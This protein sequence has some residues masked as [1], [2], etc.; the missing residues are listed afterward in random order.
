MTTIDWARLARALEA[1]EPLAR[2]IDVPWWVTADIMAVTAPPEA[3]SYLLDRN[4]KNLVASGEQSF[5][6]MLAKGH[7]T[8][9]QVYQTITPC[10]REEPHG[11]FHRKHFMKLE[12]FATG[13]RDFLNQ[14]LQEVAARARNFF[15][16][17]LGPG[18][19]TQKDEQHH[20]SEPGSFDLVVEVEGHS[21]E[22]GS[23]GL[24]SHTSLGTW[25]YATGCAEPRMSTV[26]RMLQMDE[27][28]SKPGYHLVEIP[29]G[30]FGELSKV[31]EELAE[32]LD[33][34]KQGSQLMLLQELSDLVGA[35]G[36]V[37]AKHGSS[38]DELVR[39]AQITKR[40]FEAGHRTS[41]A[42]S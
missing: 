38:L 37:A 18:H 13:T 32:A 19:L 5:L 25:M 10:F 42:S 11:R 8:H 31:A 30:V 9:N 21:Y 41:K 26:R 20:G 27:A 23:Y 16:T 4:Q 14:N 28:P 3:S 40:A 6:Y 17:E 33:A 29:R 1:Y 39:M 35:A 2:Y 36:A 12:L 22:L 15:E 24:R 34:E 7:L